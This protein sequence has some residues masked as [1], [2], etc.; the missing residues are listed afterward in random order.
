MKFSMITRS[1][2]LSVF[3][4]ASFAQAG[5]ILVD[6]GNVTVGTNTSEALRQMGLAQTMAYVGR[7]FCSPRKPFFQYLKELV[8][9]QEGLPMA[10]DEEGNQLPQLMY[11]WLMST[12]SCKEI[13]KTIQDALSQDASLS[14]ASK[15]VFSNLASMMFTP[16]EFIKTKK[17]Y[18]EMIE[19]LKEYK[20][21]GHTLYVCSNW[22]AESFALFEKQYPEFI[23]L[24][25][26]KIVSGEIHLMKPQAEFFNYAMAMHGMNAEQTAL[27]DDQQENVQAAQELCNITGIICPRKKGWIS[28]KPDV[29]LVRAQLQAWESNVMPKTA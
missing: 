16:E 22:D 12:K 8:P 17:F 10:C 3:C 2:V 7:H 18:P 27:I 29:E 11:D 9:H 4:I 19:L 15:Y 20:A 14:Y 13:N 6:L 25:D 1:L 23:N 24:F 21:K 5:N 28:S 26:G